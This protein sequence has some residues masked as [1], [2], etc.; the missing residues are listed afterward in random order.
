MQIKSFKE[1]PIGKYM[2]ILSI[3]RNESLDELDKQIKVISILNDLTEE[4][5]LDLPLP[6]Y[7]EMVVASRF[8]A[9]APKEVTN[10]ADVVKVEQWELLAV[11]DVS[12]ITTSQYVDFQTFA[13]D[14]ERYMV[15]ILSCFLIPKGCSYCKGYD[16]GQLQEALRDNLSVADVLSLSAFFFGQYSDLM[17]SFLFSLIKQT[18]DLNPEQRQQILSQLNQ[19]MNSQRNGDGSV[20]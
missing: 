5:V 9:V 16:I 2:D 15:E 17:S 13:K 20:M 3:T 6:T 8:L 4:E 19:L 18:K 1:L 11:K 10:A 12:K 7:R 14:P